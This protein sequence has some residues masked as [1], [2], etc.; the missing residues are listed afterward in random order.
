MT[1]EKFCK[2]IRKI[3][4]FGFRRIKTFDD[5]TLIFEGCHRYFDG[6][7]M[8]TIKIYNEGFSFKAPYGA[9]SDDNVLTESLSNIVGRDLFEEKM[10]TYQYP[11]NK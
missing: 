3:E 4:W 8:H 10:D 1:R 5:G 9:W 11:F 6:M 7:P 2:E